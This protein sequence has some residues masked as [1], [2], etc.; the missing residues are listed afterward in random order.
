MNIKRLVTNIFI[1]LII[2]S[3]V[4]GNKNPVKN[5]FKKE[6]PELKIRLDKLKEEFELEKKEIQKRYQLQIDDI[7]EQKRI[8]IKTLRKEFK[9]RRELL[10]NEFDK[11]PKS[12]KRTKIEKKKLRNKNIKKTK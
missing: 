1:I 6:N 10:F 5:D 7:K 3:F 12:M 2:G 9:D 4:L 11:D 8:E